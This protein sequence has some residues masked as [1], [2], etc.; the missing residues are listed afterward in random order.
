MGFT[1]KKEFSELSLRRKYG[2]CIKE[3]DTLIVCS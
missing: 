1:Y 2:D 3:V